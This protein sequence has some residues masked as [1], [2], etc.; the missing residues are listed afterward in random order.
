M[1]ATRTFDKKT[2]REIARKYAR[3]GLTT[4]LAR[5]YDCHPSTIRAAITRA[6]GALRP[7]GGVPG[8]SKAAY[9]DA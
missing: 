5:E 3:G 2:E 9:Q 6:G 4:V 7:R 1:A 8:V